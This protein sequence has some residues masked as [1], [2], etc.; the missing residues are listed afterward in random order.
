[1]QATR[2]GLAAGDEEAL[3]GVMSSTSALSGHFH[4][5]PMDLLVSAGGDRIGAVR[6]VPVFCP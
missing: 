6:Y 5:P 3:G 4:L 2:R 1:M